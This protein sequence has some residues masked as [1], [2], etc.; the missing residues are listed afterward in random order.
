MENI[1]S[2]HLLTSMHMMSSSSMTNILF[3]KNTI[4]TNKLFSGTRVFNFKVTASG[5][6]ALAVPP[7]TFK[8][9]TT[10]SDNAMAYGSNDLQG[11][12]S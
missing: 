8:D 1:S 4:D 7:S 2:K 6:Q 9:N 3:T 5:T 12:D 11:H 10:T